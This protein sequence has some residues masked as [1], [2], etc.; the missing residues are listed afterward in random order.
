[1]LKFVSPFTFSFIF[2]LKLELFWIVNLVFFSTFK[3][4]F[5]FAFTVIGACETPF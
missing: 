1:M 4:V 5:S 2:I 3:A